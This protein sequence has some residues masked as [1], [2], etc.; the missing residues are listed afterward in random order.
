M[1]FVVIFLVLYPAVLYH[2]IAPASHRIALDQK[3]LENSEIKN[4]NFLVQR[5]NYFTYHFSP[6]EDLF[7]P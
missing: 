2:D 7:N 1:H 3:T 5:I 4:K 6:V